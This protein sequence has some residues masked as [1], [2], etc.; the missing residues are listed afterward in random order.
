M[1]DWDKVVKITALLLHW[2]SLPL[3]IYWFSLHP[4]LRRRSFY[5]I[6]LIPMIV[7]FYIAMIVLFDM[8]IRCSLYFNF[9]RHYSSLSED[10]FKMYTHSSVPHL[11]CRFKSGVQALT[12][13]P[14]FILHICP[15]L[16][17][18]VDSFSVSLPE[19][20]VAHYI[21]V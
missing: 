21:S 9:S 19:V 8:T 16:T 7:S 5:F 3:L 20:K 18:V 1:H 6:Y 17:E 13:I 10:R 15:S 11:P 12:H 4:L 2:F 14:V